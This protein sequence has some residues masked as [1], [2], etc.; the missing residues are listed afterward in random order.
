MAKNPMSQGVWRSAINV[1]Y[2]LCPPLEVRMADRYM[3]RRDRQLGSA[4]QRWQSIVAEFR[5]ALDNDGEYAGLL[6]AAQEVEDAE[7][8]RMETLESKAAT[9]L[10]GIAIALS[11]L[12]VIP[13]LFADEFGVPKPWVWVAVGFYLLAVLYLLAAGYYAI[14]ARRIE[15][16]ALP[17]AD[18][19]LNL[20]REG[21]RE[22][23]DWMISGIARA[24]WNEG[25]LVRK[26]NRLSASEGLFVRGVAL[27]VLAALVATLARVCAE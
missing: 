24:K 18:A 15:P 11:V 22:T 3:E 4:G 6:K 14:K 9:Y 1:V 19:V 12:S 20:A 16:L 25:A 21:R 26:S 7:Q 5:T 10:S 23:E 2:M 17:S 27:V 13:A 8:R